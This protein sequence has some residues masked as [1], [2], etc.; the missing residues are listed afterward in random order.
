M[1][2]YSGNTL[3]ADISLLSKPFTIERLLKTIRN[4]LDDRARV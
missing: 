3:P 2:G 4:V 1:S